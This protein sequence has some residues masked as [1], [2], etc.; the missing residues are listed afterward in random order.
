MIHKAVRPTRT[1]LF[2]KTIDDP[3]IEKEQISSSQSNPSDD[4]GQETEIDSGIVIED[5]I[6]EDSD[7]VEEKSDWISATR[8]L[9]SLLLRQEDA[10][11][12]KN[13]DVFGRPL[14]WVDKDETGGEAKTPFAQYL[15]NLKL[16]EEDN[17][18][19]AAEH[20]KHKDE[21]SDGMSAQNVPLGLQINQ[22]SDIYFNIFFFH[23]GNGILMIEP[24]YDVI[25]NGQRIGRECFKTVNIRRTYE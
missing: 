5:D 1:S 23:V 4:G 15:M 18:E 19:R 17:R 20:R 10:D 3:S 8:T 22:V 11:R 25:E 12:D 9:G 6:F 21:S 13:V 2:Y 24:T 14:S 16:Q 7:D